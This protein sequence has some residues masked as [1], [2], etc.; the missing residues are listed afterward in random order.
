[1]CYIQNLQANPEPLIE[2]KIRL[3]IHW[4]MSEEDLAHW[5]QMKG[6]HQMWAYEK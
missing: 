2:A 6:E 3:K 5:M 4:H 1:L